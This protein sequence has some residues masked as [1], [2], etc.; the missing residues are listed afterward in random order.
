MR[1]QVE[2]S[3]AMPRGS[4]PAA[5]VLPLLAL[6]ALPASL[7]GCGTLGQFGAGAHN[8]P[9]KTFTVTARVTTVVINGGAGS[10]DVTGSGR[11][12]ILV[13]QQ[14]SYS[15]T[16]PAV[17]HAVSGTTLTLSYTCP[18]ELVCGVAYSVQVPRG[19]AVRAAT[20]AGAITLSS[21]TGPVSA[22]T[23]AGLITATGLGSRTADLKSNAGGIVATFSAA[24][25]S[26]HASTNV[27]PI[28][29]NVPSSAAYKIDTHTYVGTS[30]VTVPR[31][32]AS[33]HVISASSDLGS[34]T[35]GPS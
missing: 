7:A 26:V 23:S 10:I 21:L 6:L 9:A 4:R 1:L 17:T 35:I 30:T 8:P 12:T 32:A 27:G 20:A 31:N 28:T 16:P 25:D 14:A 13:S 33:P 3:R 19:V 2:E 29:L 34:V 11:G 15:K 24:P 5:A 18:A 22:R